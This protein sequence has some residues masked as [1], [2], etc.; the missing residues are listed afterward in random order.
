MKDALTTAMPALFPPLGP[1]IRR[2]LEALP[3]LI[4]GAFPLPRR[5]TAALPRDVADLSRLLTSERSG[6]DDGYLGRPALLSAYLRYFLPWNVYRLARLLPALPIPLAGGDAVTDL[7]S[8]P[9]TLP[10]ALWISRPDLRPLR[11]EFRCL[12]RTPA[13][14][15]AGK[16]LFHALAGDSPWIIK[17]VKAAIGRGPAGG[18]GENRL[19]PEALRGAALVSAVYVFDEVIRYVPWADR[20]ALEREADTQARLLAAL[21]AGGG[22]VLVV[23]PGIPR[24][25][26]F[27]SLLR[28]ALIKRRLAPRAPCPHT[29]ICPFPGV[30]AEGKTPVRGRS[31][32]KWCHF[33]LD[34]EDA[35][36]SLLRLSAAAGLPKERATL[37]FLLAGGAGP[38]PGAEENNPHTGDS[39]RAPGGSK[40]HTD[41]SLPVRIISDAFPLPHHRYGRYGCSEKGLVLVSGEKGAVE[42]RAPGTLPRLVLP[43][44]ERRDPKTGALTADIPP[45][46][47]EPGKR[48]ERR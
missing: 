2:A 19:F 48:A 15:E 18:R 3:R 33:P 14:L 12:D 6:R 34:T 36:P 39:G 37:S 44:Q 26:E 46:G 47:V 23:E 25:G 20:R 40:T 1:E 17:T 7:G 16:K 4:D 35:P 24:S 21:A 32:G 31:K 30:P 43:A 27:I 10:I 9:L 41:D 13:A 5:F 42:R 11:L 22:A 8:G 29:G 38:E 28:A 45:A